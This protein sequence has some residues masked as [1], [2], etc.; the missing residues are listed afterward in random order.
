MEVCWGRSNKVRDF[1]AVGL[2]GRSTLL[3]GILVC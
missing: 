2:D 1:E 3:L